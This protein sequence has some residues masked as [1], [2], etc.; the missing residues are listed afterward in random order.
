MASNPSG[1][2][3]NYG[4]K[5]YADASDPGGT[6]LNSNSDIIDAAIK[7]VDERVDAITTDALGYTEYCAKVTQTGTA[8]PIV[9]EMR[10]TTG[11]TVIPT[12]TDVGYYNLTF[13]DPVLTAGQTENIR[14]TVYYIDEADITREGRVYVYRG[15]NTNLTIA[16]N[17]D[18]GDRTDGI[19]SAQADNA[20][21]LKI[22][23][24]S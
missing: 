9:T 16:T 13:S 22:R 18:A 14:E 3:T 6:A 15:S 1:Y 4:I 19:L 21:F 7:A 10:N 12:R 24:Y 17:N 11:A 23:I 20:W 8:V 2:T 5:K